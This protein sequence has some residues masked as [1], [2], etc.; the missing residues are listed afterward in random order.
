M[1]SDLDG[2]YSTYLEGWG[3]GVI[4]AP[5]PYSE[6]I[7]DHHAISPDRHSAVVAAAPK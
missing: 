6:R 2:G 4:K 1:L 3:G 7:P 5:Y